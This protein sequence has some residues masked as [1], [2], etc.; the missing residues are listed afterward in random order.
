MDAS[1]A[2][3]LTITV[4]IT[5]ET[6]LGAIV[7]LVV[8]AVLLRAARRLWPSSGRTL[9]STDD[10]EEVFEQRRLRGRPSTWTHVDLD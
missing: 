8:G 10:D 1:T 7:V 6:G 3:P 2:Q 4:S 5:P 9:V